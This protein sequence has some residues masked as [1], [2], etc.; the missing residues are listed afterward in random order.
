[1]L[2]FTIDALLFKLVLLSCVSDVQYS[3][4]DEE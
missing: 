1:M 3:W 4:E 2:N